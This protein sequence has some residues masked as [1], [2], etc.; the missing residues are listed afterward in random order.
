MFKFNTFSNFMY[1]YIDRNNYIHVH[2]HVLQLRTQ[3]MYTYKEL[4][5]ILNY[6]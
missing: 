5:G 4:S 2:V 6:M 1:M 3:N